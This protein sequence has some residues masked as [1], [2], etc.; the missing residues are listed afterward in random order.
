MKKNILSMVNFNSIFHEILEILAL[1]FTISAI[2][3]ILYG[4]FWSFKNIIC[5]KKKLSFDKIIRLG[6]DRFLLLGLQFLI[7]ADIID[8]IIFR[9]LNN[10][11]TVSII[12]IVRTIMSWEIKR[13]D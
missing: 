2:L 11:I 3:V 9:D 1:F 7:V 12:V 4:F 10:L 6:F 5:N 8:T 13:H